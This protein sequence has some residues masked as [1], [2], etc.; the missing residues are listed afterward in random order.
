MDRSTRHTGLR[1]RVVAPVVTGLLVVL[2]WAALSAR[3]SPTV[4]PAPGAVAARFGA[5]IGNGLLVGHTVTTLIEAV[6]GCLLATL[7]ALPL[8]Y[9]IAHWRSMDA[10]VSPYLAASQALPAVAVAPLLVIWVGYGLFPIVLLCTLIVFFP[11]VL[12]AVLGLRSLDREV[13]EAARLDGAHGLTMLRHVEEPLARPTVLTGL[14]NGFTLSVTGAVV[15]ELVMGGNGLGSIL[16]AEAS[17]VDTTGVFATLLML[18]LLATALYL[19]M[20]GVERL[21]DPTSPLPGGRP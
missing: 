12:A 21:L 16:A 15:G 11:V 17:S 20:S 14:R 9:G 6:L 19:I 10:A 8:G 4:L 3:S 1:R 5:D 18:C 2:G 13:V 7:L